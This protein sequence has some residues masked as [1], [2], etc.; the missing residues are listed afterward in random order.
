M[1]PETY[2]I[3]IVDDEELNLKM[4]SRLLSCA[5][6][7]LHTA[8]NG[9]YAIELAKKLNPDLVLLD[10]VM[11]ELDGAE[12]CRILKNTEGTGQIPV[13]MLTGHQDKDA[14]LMCLKAGANDFLTK[15]VDTVELQLR[16]KNLLEFKRHEDTR[17]SNELLLQSKMLLEEKTKKLEA[18][19]KDRFKFQDI[20]TT[21][22]VMKSALK[23]AVRVAASPQTTVVIYGESDCGKEVLS[24]AIRPAVG[25]PCSA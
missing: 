1:T 24:R 11:P 19:L 3:L 14:K 20:I 13:I 22:P 16:V 7:T 6:D 5:P 12:T 10:M 9:K 23:L 21:S 2:N 8:G 15:P 4:L 25:L 17:K 18:A